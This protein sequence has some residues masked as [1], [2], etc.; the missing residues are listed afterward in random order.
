MSSESYSMGKKQL[1][2]SLKATES[3][4][5]IQEAERRLI[6][7]GP[8]ELIEKKKI[9]PLQIFLGQF[10]DIFVIMLIIAMSISILI[11][12]TRDPEEFVD[13][14]T[15]GAIVFLNAIVGFVQEY[16][17]EKAM[18]AMKQLTA[19]KA[20]V[21]RNGTEMLIPS[22]E[23]VPGDIV[24]LEAGDRIPADARLLEVVDL[25]TDE[26]ILTGESTAVDKK[27]V[28]LDSKTPVA[29]RKNSVFMATHLTY[30]RGKAVITSTGMK[31]EFGKV[32]EMVQA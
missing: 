28:V 27:D 23:V 8:N 11:A 14:A 5:T 2:D 19:P 21:L 29:D 15:I 16:R 13:A 7:Y 10:K 17:S 24:L 31:T 30:G 32:A 20:R 6:E 3:G 12:I 9:S 25:K 4:L 26:A 18:D 1:L 22:R